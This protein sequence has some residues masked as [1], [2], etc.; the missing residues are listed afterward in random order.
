M[1]VNGLIGFLS[2]TFIAAALCSA[3]F[4]IQLLMAKL[5]GVRWKERY[6]NYFIIW[7]VAIVVFSFLRW[8]IAFFVWIVAFVEETFL[9]RF[10]AQ[11][12]KEKQTVA[13]KALRGRKR[14]RAMKKLQE[15]PSGKIPTRNYVLVFLASLLC[16]GLSAIVSTLPEAVPLNSNPGYVSM[17]ISGVVFAVYVFGPKGRHG[18][19]WSPLQPIEDNWDKGLFWFWTIF[20]SLLLIFAQTVVLLSVFGLIQ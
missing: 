19:G 7:A 18:R 1:T 9:F 20:L 2:V 14:E 13:A 11:E 3:V 8:Y 5:N 12:E 15:K 17:L 16:S 4:L 10:W 6:K